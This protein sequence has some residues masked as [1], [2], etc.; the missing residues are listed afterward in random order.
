MG[1]EVLSEFSNLS[2]SHLM[3]GKTNNLDED[4]SLEKKSY[5]SAR[6]RKKSKKTQS[7]LRKVQTQSPGKR[8]S[9]TLQWFQSLK[10]T[11]YSLC[12]AFKQ[13]IILR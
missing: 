7:M 12:H 8:K 2:D 1:G 13:P 5:V 9:L 4:S 6:K 10:D 11:T 3:N